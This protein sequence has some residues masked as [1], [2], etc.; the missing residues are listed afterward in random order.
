[1]SPRR[2]TRRRSTLAAVEAAAPARRIIG[3]EADDPGPVTPITCAAD[4]TPDS[5]NANL[6]TAFGQALLRES[7]ETCGAGRPIL[8]DRRG[9]V[10]GGNKTIAA[11][12]ALG[13]E[14]EVV[15]T[16]A[17]ELVVVQRDDLTHGARKARQLAYY[18]NRVSQVDL[19]WST[20]QVADDLLAGINVA[21]AF[22][23][24]ELASI[25]AADKLGASALPLP[26][27]D[28]PEPPPPDE[29]PAPVAGGTGPRRTPVPIY[30]EAIPFDTK[31]Q[32]DQWRALLTRLSARYPSH[33]TPGARVLALIAEAP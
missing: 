7:F 27:G 1:M 15:P 10:I 16:R 24:D 22:D 5:A 32:Y 21:C 3:D 13:L 28:L 9:V 31:A 33:T 20:T 25:Q 30:R 17:N 2:T 6:G 4:L 8:A 11:A 18:D 26:P 12:I 29:A 14:V 19:V 23:P